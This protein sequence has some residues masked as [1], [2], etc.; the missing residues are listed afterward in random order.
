MIIKTPQKCFLECSK[1][2]KLK[3]FKRFKKIILFVVRCRF[4]NLPVSS[5]HD[6]CLENLEHFSR[7]VQCKY[8]TFFIFRISYR[9]PTNESDSCKSGLVVVVWRTRVSRSPFWVND[10][11]VLCANVFWTTSD[12]VTPP[13]MSKNALF[14]AI[15]F[16]WT[17]LWKCEFYKEIDKE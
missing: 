11:G 13:Q 5:T 15:F 16:R 3:K 6:K 12:V 10:A 2:T 8:T 4:P 9:L 1:S 7:P 17:T 14:T